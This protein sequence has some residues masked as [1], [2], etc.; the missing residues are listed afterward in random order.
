MGAGSLYIFDKHLAYHNPGGGFSFF[1]TLK[2]VKMLYS[3]SEL[4]DVRVKEEYVTA[5]GVVVTLK[6]GTEHWWG[7]MMFPTSVCESIT[8][9]WKGKSESTAAM[10]L[11]ARSQ[12]ALTAASKH[13]GKIA[14]LEGEVESL[15][16]EVT[17]LKADLGDERAAGE[18]ARTKLAASAVALAAETEGRTAERNAAEKAAAAA[19][20]AIAELKSEMGNLNERIAR[21]EMDAAEQKSGRLRAEDHAASLANDL[22]SERDRLRVAAEEAARQSAEASRRF[23]EYKE[24]ADRRHAEVTARCEEARAGRDEATRQLEAAQLAYATLEKDTANVISDLRLEAEKAGWALETA[25]A[26]ANTA[27]TALEREREAYETKAG[28]KPMKR[29]FVRYK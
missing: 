10:A 15:T 29:R 22:A 18:E 23:N 14:S 2:E 16:D 6:D 26:A 3:F 11:Q 27:Q 28:L 21:S 19:A 25:R 20:A 7:G 17:K 9:V 12:A 8:K 13:T 24:G 1:G 4:K 5:P